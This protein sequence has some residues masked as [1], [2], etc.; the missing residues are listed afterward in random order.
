MSIADANSDWRGLVIPAG[1]FMGFKLSSEQAED[2]DT[3]H[4]S[5]SLVS[6]PPSPEDEHAFE[7]EEL[8]GWLVLWDR[9]ALPLSEGPFA[10]YPTATFKFLQSSGI[11]ETPHVSPSEWENAWE[12][13]ERGTPGPEKGPTGRCAWSLVAFRQL[14]AQNPGRWSIATEN[15]EQ[16]KILFNK[17]GRALLFRLHDVLPAPIAGTP[18][19]DILEFRSKRSAERLAF[20]HHLERTYQRAISAGDGPLALRTEFEALSARVRDLVSVTR[21]AG[22]AYELCG[23]EA[24]LDWVFDPAADALSAFSA[25]ILGMAAGTLPK[26][27]VHTGPGL[28]GGRVSPTPYQYALLG[29][30][31]H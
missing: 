14:E 13:L 6:S 7:P 18:L 16:D 3:G 21:D 30:R 20:R 11:I 5:I 24:R 17:Q 1:N 26:V 19:D 23:L 9:L 8:P 29:H 4:L 25:A 28:N 15:A 31:T 22:L 2:P 27:E 12:E 10:T